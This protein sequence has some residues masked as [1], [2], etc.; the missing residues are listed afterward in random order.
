MRTMNRVFL[1][2]MLCFGVFGG[3]AIS[4]RLGADAPPASVAYG[5]KPATPDATVFGD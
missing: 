5:T 2:I 4:T 3:Y 1:G